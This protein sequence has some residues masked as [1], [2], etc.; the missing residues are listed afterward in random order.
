MRIGIAL[1]QTNPEVVCGVTTYILGVLQ[2]LANTDKD[3]RYILLTNSKNHE[4]YSRFVSNNAQTLTLKATDRKSFLQRVAFAIQNTILTLPGLQ[5]GYIPWNNFL[6][7]DLRSEI[8]ALAL[9]VIYFPTGSVAPL[10]LKTPMVVSMHDVQHVHYPEFFTAKHRHIREITFPAI[11]KRAARLQV[12]SQYM[13][14]DF[15]RVFG[16]GPEKYTLI[17]DG[18][19]PLF[20]SGPSS[21]V[22]LETVRAAYKLPET[23]VFYPAQHWA[24]KN[25]LTLIRALAELR[26]QGKIIHAVFTGTKKLSAEKIYQTIE[27][28]GLQ[29]QIH[30]VGNVPFEHLKALYELATVI[31]IASLH[32][33]NS[34]PLLETL[35]I[36]TPAIASDI[37][38]NVELNTNGAI[39]IFERDSSHDLAQKVLPLLEDQNLREERI[40]L[41]NEL[42]NGIS[43]D[44]TARGYV[45]TFEE[46]AIPSTQNRS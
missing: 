42:A 36:G 3:N 41:G 38:P 35:C 7:K 8:D 34:L 1:H 15:H 12:S 16:F 46:V 45:R 14:E 9:D 26:D 37:E 5:W 33:S 29:Q 18:V 4:A 17:K 24:H 27:Q 19:D 13:A 23:F 6:L 43:W 2:G 44:E 11:A 39:E 20:T 40:R 10:N 28:L 22:L 30:F 25:H 31:C 21:P 32:E